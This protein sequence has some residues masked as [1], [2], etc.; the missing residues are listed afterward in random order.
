[1]NSVSPAP[2]RTPSRKIA[3]VLLA[4]LDGI[5]ETGLTTVLC[6]SEAVILTLRRIALATLDG[7]AAR[8][9][10]VITI[11]ELSEYFLRVQ[12]PLSPGPARGK[13]RLAPCPLQARD[14]RLASDY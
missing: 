1:M 9:N 4:T 11:M 13:S 12:Q 14:R 8:M 2:N 5:F 7:Y 6:I 3:K 10:T